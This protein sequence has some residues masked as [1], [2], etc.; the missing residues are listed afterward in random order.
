[1][2]LEEFSRAHPERHETVAGHTWG[3]IETAGPA[4]A[5][6][7][8]MLPGTLGTAQIF[9]K[10]IAALGDR[11]RII[12]VTYPP[13]DNIR[14]LA[15]ALAAL[16]DHLGLG[17]AHLLG[18]SLGGYLAQWFAVQYPERVESLVL[19]NTLCDPYV[20]N[21]SR[22]PVEALRQMS[23]EAHHAAVLSAVE[24]WSEPEPI[25]RTVK[26]ILRESGRRLIPA[27]ALKARVLAVAGGGEVPPLQ[28]PPSRMTIIDC[29]DDPLISPAGRED[30]RRRYPGA[31]LLRL[32]VGG[33]YPYITRP[34][35][36]TAAFEEGLLRS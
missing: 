25:F 35:V 27:A 14:D 2:C 32:P 15:D 23:A 20:S 11:I 6:A 3:I 26:E 4:G 34:A 18:S 21:P 28:V 22:K 36:Y 31:R 7:L 5:P 1:M 12:S 8:V 30:V 13:V 19:G 29:E 10:Q 24:S 17:Q 9:W 33:H 16:L